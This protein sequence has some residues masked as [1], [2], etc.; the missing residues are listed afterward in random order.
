M[1]YK[2]RGKQ[3]LNSPKRLNL[4][5]NSTRADNCKF[6]WEKYDSFIAMIPLSQMLDWGQIM[7]LF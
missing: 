3:W 2:P 7:I 1:L 4:E 6:M 5:K